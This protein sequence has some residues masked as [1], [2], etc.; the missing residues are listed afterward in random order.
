M[1]GQPQF[2]FQRIDML[3]SGIEL[4]GVRF[5]VG[6]KGRTVAQYEQEGGNP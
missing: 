6:I 2:V 3:L 5:E 1:T 4:L